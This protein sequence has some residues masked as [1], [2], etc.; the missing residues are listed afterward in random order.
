MLVYIYI[1]IFGW[2]VSNLIGVVVL[3]MFLKGNNGIIRCCV[4]IYD[5]YKVF[6]GKD[7]LLLVK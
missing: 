7:W 5:V 6:N 2:I 3:C 4:I 1:W